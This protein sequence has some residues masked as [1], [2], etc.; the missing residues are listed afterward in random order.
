MKSKIVLV[1]LVGLGMALAYA[2]GAR[3]AKADA[4]ACYQY[5]GWELACEGCVN[6]ACPACDDGTCPGRNKVCNYKQNTKIVIGEDGYLNK[7]PLL[8]SCFIRWDCV[9]E[10]QQEYCSIPE[11]PCVKGTVGVHSQ[12]KFVQEVLSG[13]CPPP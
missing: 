7:T 5:D 6:Q 9:P 2:G 10:G 8:I 11:V 1:A 13:T 4:Y 3:H 12:S